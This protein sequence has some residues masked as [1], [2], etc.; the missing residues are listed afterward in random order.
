MTTNSSEEWIG[1]YNDR[2]VLLAE[3]VAYEQVS[4][5]RAIERVTWDVTT[6]GGHSFRIETDASR[7]NP[8]E[9]MRELRR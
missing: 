1:D 3:V 6:R 8:F 2:R 9:P 4:Y 5:S 7:G